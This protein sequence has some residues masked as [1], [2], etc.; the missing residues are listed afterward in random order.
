MMIYTEAQLQAF[1]QVFAHHL[2][3][4]LVIGLQGELGA[5]K[6]TFCRYVLNA[7]GYTGLVKSPTYALVETYTLNYLLHHFDVYRLKSLSELYDMGFAEYVTPESVCLIEWPQK[8][9]VPCLDVLITLHVQDSARDINFT[10]YTDAGRRL[11]K[12]CV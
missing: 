9:N 5:G 10:A 8:I 7:L 1:A 11:V 2:Q 4:G 3:P 12:A 6:T